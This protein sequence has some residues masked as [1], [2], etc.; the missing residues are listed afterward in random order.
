MNFLGGMVRV[1]I[2]VC[3][4]RDGRVVLQECEYID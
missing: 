3:D 4:E 2:G 1:N